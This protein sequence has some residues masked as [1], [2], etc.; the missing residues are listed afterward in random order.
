MNRLSTKLGKSF[1]LFLAY[2]WELCRMSRSTNS[3]PTGS[4]PIKAE[5]DS[6]FI[7]SVTQGGKTTVYISIDGSSNALEW[8]A[9]F[10]I[11]KTG[12]WFSHIGF[13]VPAGIFFKQVLSYLVDKKYLSSAIDIMVI[14]HSRGGSIAQLI[15][16]RLVEKGFNSRCISFG[17]PKVGGFLFHLFNH[18]LRIKH[19][20]VN[21]KEDVVTQTPP[22]FMWGHYQ[23]DSVICPCKEFGIYKVHLS[24]GK[25]LNELAL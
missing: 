6:G 12:R 14:G 20:R 9:N 8:I 13:D 19:T 11:L 15:N 18:K 7:Y 17:S 10:I 21:I 25:R 3:Y 24:Y 5:T 1:F 2:L 22:S 16:M 4:I 23:T